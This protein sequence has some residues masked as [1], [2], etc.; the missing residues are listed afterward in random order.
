MRTDMPT[1]K[2]RML[3]ACERHILLKHVID[4]IAGQGLPAVVAKNGLLGSASCAIY[5]ISQGRRG[6]I[7]KRHDS[8]F[9]TLAVQSHLL[10]ARQAKIFRSHRKRLGD[11]SARVV[12]E[13]QKRIV[14]K[15]KRGSGIRL[16]D[17][18]LHLF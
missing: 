2:S 11:A 6:V 8:L 5:Q 15:A 13:L 12:E 3:V 10:W 17:D 1:A 16:T 7:P 4:A 9:S 14:P 18:A